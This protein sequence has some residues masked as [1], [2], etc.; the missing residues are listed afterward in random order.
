MKHTISNGT[1]ATLILI[2]MTVV[3]VMLVSTQSILAQTV[4]S[5]IGFCLAGLALNK[6][7]ADRGRK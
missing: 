7:V 6:V 1:L 5:V 4:I 3:F 2:F